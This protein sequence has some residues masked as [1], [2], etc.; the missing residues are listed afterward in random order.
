[1]EKLLKILVKINKNIPLLKLMS[2]KEIILYKI[3][4][5]NKIK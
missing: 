5:K 4:N 2:N 3:L 1:M